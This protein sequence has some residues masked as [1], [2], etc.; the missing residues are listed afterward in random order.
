M[1]DITNVVIIESNPKLD[2]SPDGDF[3]KYWVAFTKPLHELTKREMSVLAEFLKMRYKLSKDIINSDRLDRVLMLDDT[4]REI[5]EIC[6][7]KTKHFQVVMSK[8]KKNGV[9]VDG[10]I[11]TQLIPTITKD[12]TGLL[13]LF[14]FKNE[15]RNKLG[16]R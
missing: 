12:G 15:L 14:N 8:F 6:K 7:M 10:K 13:I 2:M 1:E 5:R 16:S 4:K 3:F 11:S 9:I